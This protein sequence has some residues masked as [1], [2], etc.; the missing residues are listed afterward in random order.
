MSDS[1]DNNKIKITRSELW[2]RTYSV[3][4]AGR[5]ERAPDPTVEFI[6]RL[7]AESIA[8]GKYEI[9]PEKTAQP[10]KASASDEIPAWKKGSTPIYIGESETTIYSD[11]RKGYFFYGRGNPHDEDD[12]PVKGPLVGRLIFSADKDNPWGSSYIPCYKREATVIESF[13]ESDN[14]QKKLCLQ[15]FIKEVH[16][17]LERSQSVEPAFKKL[18]D[19]YEHEIY[20]RSKLAKVRNRAAKALGLD[21][22][23]LS[24]PL[25]KIEKAVSDKLFGKVK[26]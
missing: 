4:A 14:P 19:V 26:E 13:I 5:H 21:N 9:I 8:S 7:V 2:S 25:K 1:K 22:V 10:Q 6:D 12:H 24:K 3:E 17:S 15:E 16:K 20:N 11:H 23:K 18:E